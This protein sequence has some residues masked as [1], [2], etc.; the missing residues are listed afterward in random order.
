MPSCTSTAA[1]CRQVTLGSSES[2]CV[3]SQGLLFFLLQSRL[4]S[5]T[6]MRTLHSSRARVGCVTVTSK[7]CL[8]Q[9]EALVLSE[10][11]E[12]PLDQPKRASQ[13]VLPFLCAPHF[14]HSDL[15]LPKCTHTLIRPRRVIWDQPLWEYPHRIW[16]LC[17]LG[18]TRGFLT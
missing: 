14:Q 4:K 16:S 1:R 10:D 5:L 2:F 7:H 3:S 12:S 17:S 18:F 11:G 6:A 8:W 13:D 15:V 9:H